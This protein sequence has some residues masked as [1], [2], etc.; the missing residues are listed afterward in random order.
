MPVTKESSQQLT[1]HNQ[2]INY[3]KLFQ[4]KVPGR[5]YIHAPVA[6]ISSYEAFFGGVGWGCI[7]ALCSR[8]N[9]HPRLL[10]APTP[11]RVLSVGG[12]GGRRVKQVQC[13]KLAF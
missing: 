12:G 9:I 10:H 1:W 7:E 3:E 8:K 4:R 11:R 5:N 13:G 6:S 2:M